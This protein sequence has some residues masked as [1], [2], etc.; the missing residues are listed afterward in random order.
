[1]QGFQSF[2][3]EM[4]ADCLWLSV[5]ATPRG[6]TSR[7]DWEPPNFPKAGRAPLL[8]LTRN[9]PLLLICVSVAEPSYCMRE[10]LSRSPTSCLARQTPPASSFHLPV[11]EWTLETSKGVQ[12]GW[13]NVMHSSRKGWS[14]PSFCLKGCHF[15][16]PLAWTTLRQLR[17][18][19]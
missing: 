5:I 8:G 18:S 3:P 9:T 6:H 16:D 1:M 2:S 12:G 17:L 15:T 11:K 19:L 13:R 10:S 14:Y 7:R 4:I